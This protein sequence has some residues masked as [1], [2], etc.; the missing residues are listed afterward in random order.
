LSTG[1][2]IADDATLL[3][4]LDMTLLFKQK[5]VGCEAP[6]VVAD[7]MLLLTSDERHRSRLATLL[8]D[9]QG[10]AIILDRT[11]CL[12]PGD[13]L[14]AQTGQTVR[15]EAANESLMRIQADTELAL[16]RL[17]YHLANRHVRAMLRPGAIYIEPD[18]VLAEMVKGLGGSVL[19]VNE[20]FLP[21][22][23]AYVGSQ[24]GSQAGSH[25]H[26]HHGGCDADDASMGQVG[27]ALSRAA[28]GQSDD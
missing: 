6:N 2:R 15:I 3:S 11:E 17:V 27:E 10:A 26:H 18:A 7:Q 24:A 1:K 14:V 22:S 25:G 21:E 9:G 4:V 13:I 16:M 5:M 12:Q 28:H 23:G 8:P 20:P 19:M